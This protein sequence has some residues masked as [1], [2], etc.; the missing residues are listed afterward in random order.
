MSAHKYKYIKW[1]SELHRTDTDIAG[2]KGANLGE[3]VNAGIP[4]L[5]GFVVTVNA[6]FDFL[7]KTSLK[8][9]I[10]TELK[11]LDYEDSKALQSASAR[12][13]KAFLASELPED[14]KTDVTAAYREL[15]GNHDQQVA[16][17]SSATAEDLPDAS[18]AGQQETFLNTQGEKQVLENL[19]RCY[20]SLFEARAIYY[21]NTEK[22]DH[23]KVGLA[24]PIQIMGKFEV[25][26]IM[27]TANPLTSDES[28]IDIEAAYGLAEPV[29][30]G[31]LTPDQYLIKKAPLKIIDKKIIRQEWQ[32]AYSGR[33]KV[34]K[35]YQKRQKLPDAKILELAA[36]GLLINEHYGHPQD[37][38]WGMQSGKLFLVQSRPITTLLKTKDALDNP[39]KIDDSAVVILTG[40]AASPGVGSG[41]V[42]ILK[43]ASEINKLKDGEVLVT[44]MTDPDYVP[45]MK[46]ASAIVTDE[47]GRTS[48]AAIVS[49]ELG[50]PCVVGT[51][52]A[53]KML[54]TG[55][56]IT[57]DG[58]SGK[59]YQ[60]IY[61][62]KESINLSRYDDPTNI[63]TATK[64]YVDL[65][66]P[67]LAAEVSQR[68]VDGVGLMRAEFIIAQVIG[69]HPKA[70]L[71]AGRGREFTD[72]LATGIE[73]FA[74]AFN[75]RQIVYRAT[76]FKT[77][78]YRSLKGGAKYEQEEQNPLMGY[79]GVSRYIADSAVFELE[80]KA[81]DKV[82]NKMG[83]KNVHLMLPF[84]RT[85][86]ELQE[87]KKI[88]S[89]FGLHRS[90]NFKL[91]IMVE[92]PS[93]VVMLDEML[94]CGVDGVSVGTNDLTMLML[95]CD[96][97]NDKVA[98]IYDE[99]HP[100]VMW[101][102]EKIVKTCAKHGV[103]S[104]ICGQ[105]PSDYPEIT[106]KLVEWGITSVSIN[107]DVIE[108]T[109]QIVHDAELDLAHKRSRK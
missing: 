52:E 88:V 13:R 72:K 7:D 71:S 68:Y 22:Y 6:Y 69:E 16:V 38:E 26:G 75:P 57:V 108:K 45:A 63:K 12:I 47:G 90:A 78:E 106:R 93:A 80:L 66:V 50:V 42:R 24:S 98:N 94:D 102:L 23:F 18:F 76:D 30:L 77:N 62:I 103:T 48:H 81:L 37:T 5:P 64:V 28:Q 36:I 11:D 51:N 39:E 83:Y 41:K 55:E 34:S 46:R 82:R 99:R 67:E 29:V 59:I 92:V 65:S 8:Q 9:K 79:R 10:K 58:A 73:T 89:A 87:V 44:K 25:A 109:R 40:S 91:W 95:G 105:A 86:K 60:G 56:E 32:R 35:D 14:I 15:C 97:D 21:R 1:F 104:S 33:L 54:R 49:R 74:K 31:E 101:A 61:Q 96:R 43:N 2:G 17:R 107:V 100:A 20:A 84:V 27:F 3:L 19:L 70:M 53:T 4:V 85:V